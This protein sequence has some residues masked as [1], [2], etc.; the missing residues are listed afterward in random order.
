VLRSSFEEQVIIGPN[1]TFT[2]NN[3]RTDKDK[4]SMYFRTNIETAGNIIYA[5]F[6]AANPEKC[7]SDLPDC[8]SPI[9]AILPHRCRLAQ[10]FY[11]G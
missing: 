2:F 1:Y 8:Q 11:D 6:K 5:G 10:S 7:E 9:L 4:V 3:Q